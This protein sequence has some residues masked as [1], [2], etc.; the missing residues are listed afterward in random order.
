MTSAS[1]LKRRAQYDCHPQSKLRV[2]EKFNFFFFM[3][4]LEV[5]TIMK[6]KRQGK[7]KL[8][9]LGNPKAGQKT[10]HATMC[11]AGILS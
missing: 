4:P 10:V 7:Q 8:P 5:T 9:G 11:N 6:K 3:A 1:G 2:G